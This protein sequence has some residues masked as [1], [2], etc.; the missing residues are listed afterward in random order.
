MIFD[1]RFPHILSAVY[2]IPMCV[3]SV[4]CGLAESGPDG[5]ETRP[6]GSMPRASGS[7]IPGR[8]D[9]CHTAGEDAGATLQG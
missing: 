8:Q 5:F 3:I 2:R 9:A 1:L 7:R 6:Y 4:I